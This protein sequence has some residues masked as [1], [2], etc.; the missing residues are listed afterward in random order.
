MPKT[1]TSNKYWNCKDTMPKSKY[2]LTIDNKDYYH[3][4]KQYLY[5]KHLGKKKKS[6]LTPV[7][8]HTF[9]KKLINRLV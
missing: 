3:N 7:K 9:V 5:R 2:L 6:R 1:N 8:T 4:G